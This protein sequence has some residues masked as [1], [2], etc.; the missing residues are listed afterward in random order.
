[1][2]TSLPSSPALNSI[3]RVA[4][5]D[6]GVPSFMACSGSGRL[7][8]EQ[9]AKGVQRRPVIDARMGLVGPGRERPVHA[10]QGMVAQ[11]SEQDVHRRLHLRALVALRLDQ[12]SR[13]VIMVTL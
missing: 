12:G 2:A 1:M 10:G 4:D 7:G 3:T 5:G 9:L 8:G 6:S 13:I 11:V